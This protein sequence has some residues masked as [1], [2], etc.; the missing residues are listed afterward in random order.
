MPEPMAS[1]NPLVRLVGNPGSV[2][3]V[4]GGKAK[5]M[6]IDGQSMERSAIYPL[7]VHITIERSTNF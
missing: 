6:Q 7:N 1:G 5:S 2:T 3:A 4:E